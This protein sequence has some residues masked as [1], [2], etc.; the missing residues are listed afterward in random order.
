MKSEKRGRETQKTIE[1]RR[2]EQKKT[3]SVLKEVEFVSANQSR[4]TTF[5]GQVN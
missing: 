2:K 5:D 4:D 1:R 3:G